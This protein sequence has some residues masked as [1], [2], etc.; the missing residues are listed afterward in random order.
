MGCIEEDLR[1][2]VADFL[3]ERSCRVYHEVRMLNRWI[4]VVAIGPPGSF[5]I[6]LKVRDWRG[7]LRQAVAYQLAA[8]YSLVALPWRP[9]LTA[10]R[11]RYWLEKEGVGLLA[12]DPSRGLVRILIEPEPSGRKMPTLMDSM[13]EGEE[14]MAPVSSRTV[15]RRLPPTMFVPASS[16]NDADDPPPSSP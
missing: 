2:H 12:V 5:A 14:E 1:P 11:H 8:D 15:S 3:R 13:F 6:E 9:S 4:D 16:W 10:Y 7:A